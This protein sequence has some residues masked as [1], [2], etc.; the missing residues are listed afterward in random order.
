MPFMHGNMPLRRTF[1]FLSQGKIKFRD[2]VSIFSMGFHRLPT[3]EQKGA[4]DFVYWHWAQ[5]QFHNPSVQLVKHVDTVITPF[6]KAYLNDGREVLFDL[7]NLTKEDIEKQLVDTLGKTELVRKREDLEAIAK[8][9]PASF[10][11]KC[12][13]QCMCEIQG[14]H[15]CTSLLYAPKYLT[16]KHKWNHNLI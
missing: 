13:R 7:E 2:N 1:F 15:P 12:K 6:A 10:G 3:D 14:Q 16:G 4:R 11:S 5:L 9:N 8:V